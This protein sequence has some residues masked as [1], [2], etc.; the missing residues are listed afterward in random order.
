MPVVFESWRNQQELCNY[1]FADWATLGGGTPAA[2]PNNMFLDAVLYPIGAGDGI[3]LS[4]IRTDGS[5]VVFVISDETRELATGTFDT[6]DPDATDTIELFDSYGR[7]AGVLVGDPVELRALS[8]WSEGERTYSYADTGFTPTVLIPLPQIGVRGLALESGEILTGDC[9]VVGERGVTLTVDDGAI[10]IDL[11]GDTT[12]RRRICEQLNSY[13][14]PWFLRTIN[15][16][17]P[18]KTGSFSIL[19]GTSIA[20]DS[21]LRIVPEGN[22]LSIS[23]AG[24]S[25]HAPA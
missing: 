21:A 18:S 5:N 25:I 7:I 13:Q 17:G 20:V 19:P 6:A 12:S 3:H 1:P 15:F 4:A 11:V 24:K 16:M 2:L 8:S 10:R 22:G 9:W 23:L 14:Q